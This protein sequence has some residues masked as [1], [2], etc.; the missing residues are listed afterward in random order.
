MRKP[1]IFLKKNLFCPN[2]R[3]SGWWGSRWTT[4]GSR[5]NRRHLFDTIW[6][7]WNTRGT[8]SRTCVG[9]SSWRS[10][11]EG[12]GWS[13]THQCLWKGD[14]GCIVQANFRIWSR[15]GPEIHQ[16][17]LTLFQEILPQETCSETSRHWSL[18]TARSCFVYDVLWIYGPG[19]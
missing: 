7:C 16:P 10:G 14:G 13:E 17:G 6:R 3:T 18:A 5:M 19:P 9:D 12:E 4:G 1:K 2:V 8:G 15:E 11:G